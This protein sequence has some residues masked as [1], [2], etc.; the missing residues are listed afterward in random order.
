MRLTVLLFYSCLPP[1]DVR[2]GTL[3]Y[4]LD[5][6]IE[7][8]SMNI[9]WYRLLPVSLSVSRIAISKENYKIKASLLK[10]KAGIFH[11]S[12]CMLLVINQCHISLHILT[13]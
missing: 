7:K 10:I 11:F 1:T 13:H 9:A 3:E 4:I 2:S 5:E 12:F 8:C 6:H